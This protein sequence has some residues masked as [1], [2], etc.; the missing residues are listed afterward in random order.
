MELH[1][2]TDPNHQY[3]TLGEVLS[4][5]VALY[6]ANHD[7]DF[8]WTFDKKYVLGERVPRVE[9]NKD[10]LDRL[11]EIFAA[12]KEATNRGLA[13]TNIVDTV[14]RV[15]ESACTAIYTDELLDAIC[16]SKLEV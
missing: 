11:T 2:T 10:S 8:K 3:N 7:V 5:I 12:Y 1:I 13:V 14:R 15:Y 9:A 6:A 16:N 4:N